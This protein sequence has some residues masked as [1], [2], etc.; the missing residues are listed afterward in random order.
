MR[1]PPGRRPSPRRGPRSSSGAA[2]PA[3][4]AFPRTVTA[5]T[6]WASELPAVADVQV[7]AQGRERGHRNVRGQGMAARRPRPGRRRSVSRLSARY[8]AMILSTNSSLRRVSWKPNADR[9][10]PAAAPVV[11]GSSLAAAR[12]RLISYSLCHVLLPLERK[13]SGT[14]QHANAGPPLRR[15]TAPPDASGRRR[16]SWGR[17]RSGR[18]AERS[19]PRRRPSVR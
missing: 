10:D 2:A 13:N 14:G 4:G 9:P 17:R 7:L 6:S 18:P 19:G 16:T 3:A 12:N 1:P 5:V 11:R 15:R 8:M